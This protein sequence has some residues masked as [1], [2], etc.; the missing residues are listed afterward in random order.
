MS[1]YKAMSILDGIS[2]PIQSASDTDKEVQIIDKSSIYKR[3]TRS[4]IYLNVRCY[5]MFRSKASGVIMCIIPLLQICHYIFSFSIAQHMYA[6]L[7][8]GR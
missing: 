7:T 3:S 4:S 1:Y 5:K 6:P 8:K 2:V